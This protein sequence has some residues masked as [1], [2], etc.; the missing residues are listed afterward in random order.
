MKVINWYHHNSKEE[1]DKAFRH[2]LYIGRKNIK[3]DL[4]QS[5]LANPFPL[6]QYDREKS[7]ELYRGHLWER[8]TMIEYIQA[9]LEIREDTRLVCYCSPKPCHGDII[10]KARGWLESQVSRSAILGYQ[11]QWGMYQTCLK[12]MELKDSYIYQS[13]YR[14]NIHEHAKNHK[15]EAMSRL[16][17]IMS[18]LPT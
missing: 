18:Q 9:L 11:I 4:N 12:D 6:T 13:G 5:I 8:L 16:E 14:A 17:Y 15:I 3:L 10:L 2:W 1:L 7:L